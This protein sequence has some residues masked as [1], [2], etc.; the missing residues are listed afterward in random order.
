MR[1]LFSE[2]GPTLYGKGRVFFLYPGHG[3]PEARTGFAYHRKLFWG[4]LQNPWRLF[5]NLAEV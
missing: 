5:Q 2:K 4:N 1:E 3:L